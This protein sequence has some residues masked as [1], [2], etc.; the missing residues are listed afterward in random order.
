MQLRS[1][2]RGL[3]LSSILLLVACG[4]DGGGGDS[5]DG[6]G[7]Q[8]GEAGAGGS[9]AGKPGTG[10]S[11]DGG[12]DA[13]EGGDP[14]GGTNA[15]AGSGGA[16][17]AGAGGTGEGGTA[18]SGSCIA[19]D[20]EFEWPVPPESIEVPAHASWKNALALPTDPFMAVPETYDPDGVSWVKF[21]VLLADPETVY[22]QNSNVYPFHYD[23]A[24]ERIPEFRGLSRQRFDALTLTSEERRAVLGAVL[25]P[26]D[27]ARHA[28]Y[29][30]QLVLNDAVHPELVRT[31]VDSVKSAV[32]AAPGTDA[33]YFPST[34]ATSR[35]TVCPS[36]RS[37]AGWSATRVT[38]PAGRSERS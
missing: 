16:A 7:G 38:R 30:I 26:N 8:S 35:S 5:D 23:F 21:T 12:T 18:G 2:T 27:S 1:S 25:V 37:I 34:R 33:L 13:G 29:A 4:D 20:A 32:T 14:S 15:S 3:F 22:F 6:L 9:N 17:G 19:A 28:E 10:G 11:T 31:I 36:A 24:T